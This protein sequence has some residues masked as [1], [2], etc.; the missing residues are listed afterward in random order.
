MLHIFFPLEIT[1]SQARNG[2]LSTEK[3]ACKMEKSGLNGDH[4]FGKIGTRHRNIF[5][6]SPRPFPNRPFT[7]KEETAISARQGEAWSP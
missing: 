2:L 7:R 1:N 6:F 4:S 3:S 5:P